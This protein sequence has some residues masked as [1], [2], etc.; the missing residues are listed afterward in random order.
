MVSA[1]AVIHAGLLLLA[2]GSSQKTN[3]RPQNTFNSV[4]QAHHHLN[5]TDIE[6][7]EL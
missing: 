2:F 6:S 3:E 5:V 4:K 7:M 1:H